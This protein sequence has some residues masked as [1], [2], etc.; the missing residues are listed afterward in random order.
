MIRR[1]PR[2][3]RTDTLVPY[4]TLFRFTGFRIDFLTWAMFGLPIV[5]MAIPLAWILLIRTTRLSAG[6]LDP[7]MLSD[8]IGSPGP[9]RSEEHKSELQSLMRSSYAVLCLKKKMKRRSKNKHNINR[10]KR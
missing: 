1:P 2:S 5:V 7:K 9:W 3:T 6:R 4:T 8:A 10:Q